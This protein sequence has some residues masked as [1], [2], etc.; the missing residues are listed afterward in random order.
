M[1]DHVAQGTVRSIGLF[2]ATAGVAGE[3][4]TPTKS[5]VA[6]FEVDSCENSVELLAE[7]DLGIGCRRRKLA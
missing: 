5:T 3:R 1:P 7:E 6:P 4:G 2:E